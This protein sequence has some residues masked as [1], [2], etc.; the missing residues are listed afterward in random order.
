MWESLNV[1]SLSSG[2]REGQDRAGRQGEQAGGSNLVQ[3][4]QVG[5][6]HRFEGQENVA[7]VVDKTITSAGMVQF[8][9]SRSDVS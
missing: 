6:D 1:S 8:H 5:P 4:C 7:Y 9:C 2:G 3:S